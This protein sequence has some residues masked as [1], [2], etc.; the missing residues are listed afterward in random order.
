MKNK[1]IIIAV[2]VCIIIAGAIV[3]KVNNGFNF[4][5]GYGRTNEIDLF[6]SK[7][8]DTNEIEQIA[9]ETLGTNEVSVRAIEMYGDSVAITAKQISEEQKESLINKV[10]E[11]YGTDIKK[12]NIHIIIV[13]NARGRDIVKKLILPFVVVTAIVL[14]YMIIRY[15]KLGFGKVLIKTVAILILS[16]VELLSIMA[17]T[18]YPIGKTTTSLIL[19]VYMFTLMGITAKFEQNLHEIKKSEEEE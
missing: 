11:K 15:F 10:N 14:I 13:A 9:K 12:D 4:E 3:A 5:L 7:G 18:R 17:I 8:C 16:Q 2:L 6:I 19:I 1:K